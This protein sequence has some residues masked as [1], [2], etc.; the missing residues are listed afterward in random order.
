MKLMMLYGGA[1]T[2]LNDA[3]GI[4]VSQLSHFP[5]LHVMKEMRWLFQ[6]LNKRELADIT[7]WAMT[8]LRS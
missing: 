3:C 1:N 7:M 2:W 6:T 5:T 4:H 8:T